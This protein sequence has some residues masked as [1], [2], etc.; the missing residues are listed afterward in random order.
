MTQDNILNDNIGIHHHGKTHP[1][2]IFFQDMNPNMASLPTSGK[3]ELNLFNKL[4]ENVSKQTV[5]IGQTTKFP[6]VK[7]GTYLATLK[8]NGFYS[9]VVL[10]AP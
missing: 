10:N 9:Q 6:K 8:Q 1:F 7:S 3:V 2:K 4:G 5:D